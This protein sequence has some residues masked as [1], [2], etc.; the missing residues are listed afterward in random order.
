MRSPRTTHLLILFQYERDARRV[1]HALK[2]RLKRFALEVAEDKT[3]ILPFG[4]YCGTKEDFEFLGFTFYNMRT[5][6]QKYRVGNT[7]EQEEAES[8]ETGSEAMVA[9]ATAHAC[10]LYDEN[11]GGGDTRALQLLRG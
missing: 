4:R 9:R 11:S 7:H 8:E 10:Y 3:R 6:T 5:R 2:E 1:L